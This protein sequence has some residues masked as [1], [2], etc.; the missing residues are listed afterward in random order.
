MEL[1][2][3]PLP[4]VPAVADGSAY[5]EFWLHA[6]GSAWRHL[7]LAGVVANNGPV[8]QELLRTA[9]DPPTRPHDDLPST[10]K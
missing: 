7:A 6:P 5:A 3:T 2:W 9:G 8:L 10:A 1:T 4:E